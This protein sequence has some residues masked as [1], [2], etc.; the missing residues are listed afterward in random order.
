MVLETTADIKG[1]TGLRQFNTT[2]NDGFPGAD[3]DEIRDHVQD[4]RD[5]AP[6]DIAASGLVSAVELADNHR[7]AEVAANAA[8]IAIA[9]EFE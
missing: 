5:R 4:M 9:A 8:R 7:Q 2:F 6:L 3:S 1:P